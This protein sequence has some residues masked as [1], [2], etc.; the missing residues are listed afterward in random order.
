MREGKETT[1]SRFARNVRARREV[2]GMSQG[3]LAQAVADQGH[4]SF[5]QQTIAEIESGNRQVKLDEAVALS[6]ALGI[7]LDSLMRPAG[8]TR[9]AG[10]LLDAAREA[11]EA[12]RQAHSWAR[13][14]ADARWRLDKAIGAAAGNEAPLADE[15]AVARRA[16][17][18][19]ED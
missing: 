13:Q 7:S 9:Q 17:A 16:L 5:R 3:D 12:T 14:R 4:P 15:L 1:A 11:R 18:E 19:T 2:R 10:G 8:L 6:R